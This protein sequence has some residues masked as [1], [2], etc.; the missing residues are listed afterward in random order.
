MCCV[1]GVFLV[2]DR[3]TSVC[4]RVCVYVSECVCVF[5]CVCPLTRPPSEDNEISISGL[6][7][8]PVVVKSEAMDEPAPTQP[9]T[10]THAPPHTNAHMTDAAAVKFA[11]DEAPAAAA[12]SEERGAAGGGARRPSLATSVA[13]SVPL[14]SSASPPG[15]GAHCELCV[16]DVLCCVLL[17][18]M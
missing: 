18:S 1:C 6:P 8:A 15:Y 16:C 2:L 3:V 9:H 4:L 10:H 7:P 5:V 17:S 12:A 13:S 14:S 11:A